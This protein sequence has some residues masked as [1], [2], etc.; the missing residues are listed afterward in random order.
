MG[1]FS[2]NIA[3]LLISRF[4]A[5]CAGAAF[6]SVAGGSVSVFLSE[7]A[8]HSDPDKSCEQVTDMFKPAEVGAPSKSFVVL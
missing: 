3:T 2:N 7:L 8:I 1:A 6:L 5:G 4:F